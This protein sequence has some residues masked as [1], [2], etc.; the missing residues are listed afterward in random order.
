VIL[1]LF[2]MVA[3]QAFSMTLLYLS[4]SPLEDSVFQGSRRLS[5]IFVGVESWKCNQW[6]EAHSHMLIHV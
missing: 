6:S 5:E 4:P 1:E 2:F 3:A